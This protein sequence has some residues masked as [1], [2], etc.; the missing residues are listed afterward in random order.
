MKKPRFAALALVVHLV[1]GC[2]SSGDPAPA[3]DGGSGDTARGDAPVFDTRVAP[4]PDAPPP[5]DSLPSDDAPTADSGSKCRGSGEPCGECMA[6]H[7][8]DQGA[9]CAAD[10]DCQSA[11]LCLVTACTKSFD[12][13][14]VDC[15]VK[16]N[17]AFKAYAACATSNG[18]GAICK[19]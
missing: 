1:G 9:A 4:F 3:G 19:P 7:C 13:C 12:E 6:A 8:C 5:D 16:G 17:A 15:N 2:S 10:P 18:C 11:A 14:A